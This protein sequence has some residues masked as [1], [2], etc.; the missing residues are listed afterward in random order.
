MVVLSEDKV[1]LLA[2]AHRSSIYAVHLALEGP[3]CASWRMSYLAEFSVKLPIL[4]F[5]ALIPPQP[6]PSVPD[7][8]EKYS[9]K[10]NLYCV[11]TKCIQM[12]SLDLHLCIPAPEDQGPPPPVQSTQRQL[13]GP[14]SM[15]SPL[16]L[17]DLPEAG[18]LTPPPIPTSTI[19][20]STVPLPTDLPPLLS[21]VPSLPPVLPVPPQLNPVVAQGEGAQ[22][23]EPMTV[24]ELEDFLTGSPLIVPGDPGTVPGSLSV[25]LLSSVPQPAAV[26][27]SAPPIELANEDPPAGAQKNAPPLL[28]TPEHLMFLLKGGENGGTVVPT[29]GKLTEP[30]GRPGKGEGKAPNHGPEAPPETKPRPPEASGSTLKP[31]EKKPEGSGPGALFEPIGSFKTPRE[32]PSILGGVQGGGDILRLR[33]EEVR[34]F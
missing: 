15:A 6:D 2:N 12:Y 18:L 34:I 22:N 7:V 19:P 14:D 8:P 3:D 16:P 9:R 25:P 11:Q 1:V 28:L 23:P 4:S 26:A 20:T 31:P 5:V 10:V 33:L 27:P 17:Q 32:G 24:K 21:T 13:A 29:S 30:S